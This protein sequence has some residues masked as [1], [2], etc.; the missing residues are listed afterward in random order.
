MSKLSRV[1]RVVSDFGQCSATRH[2]KP[3]SSHA[4][5][6]IKNYSHQSTGGENLFS[7]FLGM[8]F[9]NDVT[10]SRLPSNIGHTFL[11][12]PSNIGHMFSTYCMDDIIHFTKN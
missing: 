11:R 4:V 10:F 6:D 5:H 9:R 1:T 8:M 2:S 12:L 3:P 7:F